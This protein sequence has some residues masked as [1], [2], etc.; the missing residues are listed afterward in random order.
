MEW[1]LNA[2]KSIFYLAHLKFQK[3]NFPGISQ[4]RKSK[5][6][7]VKKV[8]PDCHFFDEAIILFHNL[9]NTL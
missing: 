7:M 2:G 8:L 6:I 3:H 5:I 4:K 1:Y 9:I